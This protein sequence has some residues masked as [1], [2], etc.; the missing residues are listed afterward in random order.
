MSSSPNSRFAV[1]TCSLTK[2]KVWSLLGGVRCIGMSILVLVRSKTRFCV[3]GH[4]QAFAEPLQ[5]TFSDIANRPESL[6]ALL[7]KPHQ[8]HI[9]AVHDSSGCALPGQ[10]LRASNAPS[11]RR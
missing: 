8:W 3:S 5:P 4:A 9:S 7:C 11:L 2:G 1:V 10:R 6:L